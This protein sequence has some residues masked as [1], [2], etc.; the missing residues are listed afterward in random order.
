VRSVA[1]LLLGHLL[2]GALPSGATQGAE[3]DLS[4]HLAAPHIVKVPNEFR[5]LATVTNLGP[6]AASGLQ[7]TVNLPDGL[8]VMGL[9]GGSW[10]CALADMV[11][12]ALAALPAGASA[13]VGVDAAAVRPGSLSV[14]ATVVPG[15]D[16]AT[17]LV[18]ASG[19]PCDA[20]GTSGPDALKVAARGDVACGLRGDDV[21][22]GDRGRQVLLGGP[23]RDALGGGPDRDRLDGGTGR[24]ACV[25]HGRE[26][27]VPAFATV[28]SL[29]VFEISPATIGYGY[30]QSL[31]G[32]AVAMRPLL[33]HRVMASRGRG[34][35]TTTAVDIVVPPRG[36]IR[37]PVS[38]TVVAVE[39]YLLYCRTRDWK[40]VLAPRS[41]PRLR[42][43]ILHMARPA[44]REH[45]EVV[46]GSTLLGR[47]ARN[48]Q[49][50][51]QAN[52]Y[53]ADRYP[54]IH[55]EVERHRAAPTPGCNL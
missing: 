19:R 1:V 39:R 45:D 53:F 14:S 5:V 11:T 28:S 25:L 16:A 26:C 9:E 38:G 48:D 17:V 30:H 20:V 41:H 54:H 22:V 7:L 42:V 8:T 29:P 36:R 55:I 51:A 4:M 35:G 33:P 12:C 44:V 52:R 6:D 37:S 23:G 40:V 10:N 46:A 18:E 43:L 3:P 34:T 32:T 27:E 15:N 21:L 2:T 13:T 47:A 24:D 31:F 49:P 50:S